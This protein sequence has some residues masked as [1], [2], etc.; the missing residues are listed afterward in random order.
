MTEWIGI[1]KRSMGACGGQFSGAAG[2]ACMSGIIYLIRDWRL[3]QLVMAAPMGLVAVYIWYVWVTTC[4][5]GRQESHVMTIQGAPERERALKR[6]LG[7]KSY[8]IL[9]MDYFPQSF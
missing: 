7:H 6:V 4:S 8:I 5:S 2:L 1:T 9:F 3:A